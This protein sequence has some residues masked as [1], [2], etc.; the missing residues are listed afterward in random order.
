MLKTV[1]L[2]YLSLQI[3]LNQHKVPGTQIH[4]KWNWLRGD[5]KHL[6]TS[7][8]KWTRWQNGLSPTTVTSLEVTLSS[9]FQW[10]QGKFSSKL[11]WKFSFPY[12]AKHKWPTEAKCAPNL[13]S[14]QVLPN[15]PAFILFPLYWAEVKSDIKPFYHKHL[16]RHLR[17]WNYLQPPLYLR[18]LRGR[19]A[20]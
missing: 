18:R 3:W 11:H 2:Q 16:P 8:S 7:L 5:M 12:Q 19:R 20:D 14:A 4:S 15:T 10:G 13:L 6:I 17:I 9:V 1:L